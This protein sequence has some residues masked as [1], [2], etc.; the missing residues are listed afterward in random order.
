MDFQF[1]VGAG[2]PGGKTAHVPLVTYRYR[3]CDAVP[4]CANPFRGDSLVG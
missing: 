3:G 4:A 1:S 2:D